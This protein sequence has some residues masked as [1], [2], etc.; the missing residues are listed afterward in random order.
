MKFFPLFL[1]MSFVA[2]GVGALAGGFDFDEAD[3]DFPESDGVVGASFECGEGGFADGGER[4]AFE[5]AE[6]REVGE[7]GFQGGAKLIFG[8]A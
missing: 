7:E 1:V 3:E 6:F 2:A 5:A 8:F 4:I